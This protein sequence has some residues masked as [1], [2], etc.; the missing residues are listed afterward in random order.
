MQKRL[1]NYTKRDIMSLSSAT[2]LFDYRSLECKGI[3]VGLRKLYAR[4]LQWAL[5]NATQKLTREEAEVYLSLIEHASL[6]YVQNIAGRCKEGQ[7]MT[8]NWKMRSNCAINF[9]IY[10]VPWIS[11]G[12]H[13]EW[14][15]NPSHRVDSAVSSLSKTNSSDGVSSLAGC[16]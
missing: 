2:S 3:V 4:G 13:G 6:H 15:Q 14:S 1:I 16:A 8:K 11:S 9:P 10:L 5:I 12:L 7:F